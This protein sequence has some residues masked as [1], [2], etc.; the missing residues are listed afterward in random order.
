MIYIRVMFLPLS[1][2]TWEV[3]QEGFAVAVAPP[4][5]IASA[6][7]PPDRFIRAEWL[8]PENAAAGLE[9]VLVSRT[10]DPARIY[11]PLFEQPGL[12]R[13][14]AELDESEGAV[15]DFASQFGPLL[16]P[17]RF[18][19]P[20]WHPKKVQKL[21]RDYWETLKWDALV[22]ATQ[23]NWGFQIRRMGVIVRLHEAIT[24]GDVAA[25]DRIVVWSGGTARLADGLLPLVIGG[26][27]GER[28]LKSAMALRDQEISRAFRSRPK[29]EPVVHVQV[30]E[31]ELRV[32]PASLLGA[33]W[34]QFA[35]A[36]EEKKRFRK[37]P[38][39]NCPVVWFEVSRGPLGVREDA[40][41][42]SPRCRHTAY[43]DR[44]EDARRMRRAG[45]SMTEIARTLGVDASQVRSWTAKKK[46]G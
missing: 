17:D 32:V 12:F 44:R 34:L 19:M 16:V 27:K 42:C 18:V 1:E 21:P 7:N 38:A 10:P 4:E 24:S 6:T 13:R 31:G 29:G 15:T 35:A 11:R 3:P 36:V 9:R 39:R 43:R 41:F 46:R 40:Q 28:S 2:F 8:T 20:P 22:S 26:V 5:S 37:C 33:M 14:F 30:A 45:K 23:F 25:I